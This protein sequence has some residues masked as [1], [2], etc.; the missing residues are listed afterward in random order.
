M[1]Q[2][3]FILIVVDWVNFCHILFCSLR[4]LCL[5]QDCWSC[6]AEERREASDHRKQHLEVAVEVVVWW[7]H[8]HVHLLFCSLCWLSLM[9]SYWSCGAKKKEKHLSNG[10]DVQLTV[11][12]I[13]ITVSRTVIESVDPFS[14]Q[15]EKIS[16]IKQ[17]YSYY[18][19]LRQKSTICPRGKHTTNKSLASGS[20]PLESFPQNSACF[21]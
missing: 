12:L 11:G 3:S 14:T 13:P 16:K 20:N 21:P 7:P 4:W 6:G 15:D 10:N 19:I 17:N 5:M 2:P 8:S 18:Y 1:T 9:Q